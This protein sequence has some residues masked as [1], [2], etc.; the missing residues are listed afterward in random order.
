MSTDLFFPA[1]TYVAHLPR[2]VK[3][4]ALRA[5][6][7][8]AGVPCRASGRWAERPVAAHTTRSDGIL[9]EAT[10]GTAV[11]VNVKPA[12]P[13]AVA[14]QVIAALAYGL[15]DGAARA[16]I[17]GAPWSKPSAKAGRPRTGRALTSRERQ[18]RFRQRNRSP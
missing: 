16:S 12:S 15:M 18:R 3:F 11:V 5:W 14:R 13:E 9:A 2:G 8:L 10:P 6:C 1:P 4:K 17:A 7:A